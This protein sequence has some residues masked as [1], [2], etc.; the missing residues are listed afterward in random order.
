MGDGL[1]FA[2]HWASMPNCFLE[3]IDSKTPWKHLSGK[4]YTTSLKNRKI[5]VIE[6]Q[7]QKQ[8]K[9]S[10]LSLLQETRTKDSREVQSSGLKK[11][12]TMVIKT[13]LHKIPFTA[14]LLKESKWVSIKSY[15]FQIILLTEGFYKTGFR[16]GICFCHD[17]SKKLMSW[18]AS[19]YLKI[20]INHSKPYSWFSYILQSYTWPRYSS[21]KD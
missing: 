7:I 3:C 18:L 20:Y 12:H 10:Q 13:L 15:C 9:V 2:K 17:A 4:S 6:L 19:W 14:T 5:T 1:T 11:A 21:S 8:Y 16:A